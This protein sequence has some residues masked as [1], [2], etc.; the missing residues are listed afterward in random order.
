MS[1]KVILF[2]GQGSQAQGMGADLF[3]EYPDI[4]MIA[5]DVLGYDIT[6]ICLN[7]PDNKLN[8]TSYTQPALYLVNY[9]KYKHYLRDNKIPDYFLGHSLGEFNALGAA[10]AF[11]FETGLRIVQ[12]R[13][14]LMFS[15]TGTGMAAILG[16]EEAELSEF[17]KTKFPQIDVANINTHNQVVISGLLNV[18]DDVADAVEEEGWGYI[19]L[20][21]SGAFHSRYMTPVKATFKAFVESMPIGI[22]NKH[23]VSNFTGSLYAN[24]VQGTISNIVHQIDN[25]VR[26]LQSIEFVMAQGECD[27]VEVGQGEVLTN[28]L[29][30]IKANM[31]S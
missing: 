6:D 26:W 28:M 20:K 16:A 18:L 24:T 23:V 25:P 14:E 3:N 27:F 15:V 30:K 21:V 10:G 4:V 2:S 13:G 1:K 22:C 12:K 5:S 7:N 9:L 29:K 31:I 8:Q 11:D 17:L 19:P